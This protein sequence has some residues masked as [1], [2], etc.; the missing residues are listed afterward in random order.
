MKNTHKETPITEIQ[1][2]REQ[3]AKEKAE[4][5]RLMQEIIAMHANMKQ[6]PSFNEIMLERT[7]LLL[8]K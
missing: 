4:N 3:L 5:A 2:L 8:N 7:K 6:P 1:Y